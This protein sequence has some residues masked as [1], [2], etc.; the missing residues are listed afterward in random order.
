MNKVKHILL[1]LLFFS[2]CNS[3]TGFEYIPTYWN[4]NGLFTS[5]DSLTPAHRENI[6]HVLNYY[7]HEFEEKNGKLYIRENLESELIWNYTTKANDSD[8]LMNHLLDGK[9]K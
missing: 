3:Q 9:S 4:E 2:S 1:I 8:W 7:G 6:K 5:P